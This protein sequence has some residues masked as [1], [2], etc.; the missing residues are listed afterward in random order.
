M[1]FASFARLT[2]GTLDSVYIVQVSA[3]A[4][5]QWSILYP[6]TANCVCGGERGYTV[7]TLSIRDVLVFQYL[8]KKAMTEFHK[9][10]KFGKHIDIHKMNIYNRKIRARGQFF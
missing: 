5:V 8:E 6:P 10:K 9:F 7:F 2:I 3:F 1:A 4:K